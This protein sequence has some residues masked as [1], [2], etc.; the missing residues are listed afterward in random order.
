[1]GMFLR[2]ALETALLNAFAWIAGALLVAYLLGP[3]MTRKGYGPSA[4]WLAYSAIAAC[5]GVSSHLYFDSDT[6]GVLGASLAWL[7][8]FFVAGAF[9]AAAMAVSRVVRR[10]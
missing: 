5:A 8:M 2:F 1:M 6:G 3:A 10:K 4:R 9:I 7:A